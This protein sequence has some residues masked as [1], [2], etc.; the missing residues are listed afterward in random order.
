MCRDVALDI[1]TLS[2]RLDRGQTDPLLVQQRAIQQVSLFVSPAGLEACVLGGD[3][4]K[5]W[6]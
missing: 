5:A 1:Y 4:V 2:I 6:Y 3:S